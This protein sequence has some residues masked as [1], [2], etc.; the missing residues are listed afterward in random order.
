MLRIAE[1]NIS[2]MLEH[3]QPHLII[4]VTPFDG[5]VEQPV[6]VSSTCLATNSYRHLKCG[7]FVGATSLHF[8]SLLNG[9]ALVKNY[10][11]KR[12][13]IKASQPRGCMY[14]EKIIYFSIGRF[15]RDSHL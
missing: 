11:H 10:G 4:M 2:E 14:R 15:L 13:N 3:E 1:L 8:S 6:R 7:T 5:Y 12:S 9:M